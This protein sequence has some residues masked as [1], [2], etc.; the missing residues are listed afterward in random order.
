[1]LN[2]AVF[3]VPDFAKAGA[4]L[5]QQQQAKVDERKSDIDAGGI[6]KTFFGEG[7]AKLTPI[8]KKAAKAAYGAWKEKSINYSTTGSES[9]REAMLYAQQQFNQIWG[10]EQATFGVANQIA[11]TYK[12]NG[13][14]G[15]AE[16]QDEF[17]QKMDSFLSFDAPI[18]IKGGVVTVNGVP[19]SEHPRYSVEPNEFNRPD[20]NVVDPRSKFIDV[21]AQATSYV[22]SLKDSKFV[23]TD[24]PTYG[25]T[26][27][28]K[29]L[30]EKAFSM[31]EIDFQNSELRDGV[32]LR[33]AFSTDPSININ[34]L[35]QMEVDS[36]LNRYRSNEEMA[37]L[38]KQSYLSE[39]DESISRIMPAA[40]LFKQGKGDGADLASS[41]S[42]T[43]LRSKSD[44]NDK[45]TVSG[46]AYRIPSS[47][48]K[49]QYDG[50]DYEIDGIFFNKDGSIKQLRGKKSKGSGL[51][52]EMFD[53]QV[54]DNK[55]VIDLL[56]KSI[57]GSLGQI[58][59]GGRAAM[60]K[61][62]PKKQR[63][64]D[65]LS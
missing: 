35:S 20:V 36:I 45:G 31:F 63:A 8:G 38:A 37:E 13:G 21:N 30:K 26:Y 29:V 2:R 10:A 32:F 7:S 44:E 55:I 28:E 59:E 57:S 61:N 51:N 25:I 48:I 34:E 52:L 43:V 33:H 65:V 64:L 62:M 39:M 6:E 53:T 16:T 12:N 60:F 3:Q 19:F 50:I 56:K 42:F 49:L 15:F 23:K 22:N 58:I 46:F 41:G 54:I 17:K 4:Q 40:N 11:S 24:D 5:Q 18:E 1:M 47:P 14:K 9:D 27:N